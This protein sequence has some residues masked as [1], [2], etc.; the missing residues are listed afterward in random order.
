MESENPR[1]V[2]LTSDH[3]RSSLCLSVAHVVKVRL[4]LHCCLPAIIVVIVVAVVVATTL[5]TNVLQDRK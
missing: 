1:N 4:F 3:A 2:L 5:T